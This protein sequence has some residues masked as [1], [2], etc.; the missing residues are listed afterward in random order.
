MHKEHATVL[1]KSSKVALALARQHAFFLL[2][3]QLSLAR[4]S[5]LCTLAVSSCFNFNLPTHWNLPRSCLYDMPKDLL[6]LQSSMLAY[7]CSHRGFQPQVPAWHLK[8]VNATFSDFEEKISLRARQPTSLCN[9]PTQ[10][11]YRIFPSF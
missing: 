11:Q 1:A 8:R 4:S 9:A 5:L 6:P 10:W 7:A 2:I 3:L